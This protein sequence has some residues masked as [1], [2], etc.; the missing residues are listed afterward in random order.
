MLQTRIVPWI[1]YTEFDTV[2]QWLFADRK[3][4]IDT[5]QKGLDRV[6]KKL[7]KKTFQ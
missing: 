2:Y 1:D 4:Q 3:L 6:K 7:K 5:V